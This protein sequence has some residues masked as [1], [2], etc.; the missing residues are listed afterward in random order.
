MSSATGELIGIG[1]ELE[2]S[3]DKGTV[4]VRTE[5]DSPASLAGMM[6]GDVVLNVDGTPTEKLSAEEVAVLSR[7][8]EGTKA[9]FR[10]NRN[11]QIVD[12][13]AIRKPLKLKGTVSLG[14]T[15]VKGRGRWDCDIKIPVTIMNDINLLLFFVYL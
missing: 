6:K 11:G 7:G 4:I 9:S 3:P 1:V 10:L 15:D 14:V 8:K 5:E 12:V 2:Q 13:T